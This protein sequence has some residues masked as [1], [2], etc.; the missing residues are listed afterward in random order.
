MANYFLGIDLGGTNIKIGCLDSSFNLLGKISVPSGPD[1]T[2]EL[3]VD[4]F[5]TTS[6]ELLE[7][8][9]LSL[10]DVDA[11]GVGSP[12]LVDLSKGVV[13]AAS[14]LPLFK[15]VFLKEMVAKRMNKPTILENDANAACWGEHIIGAGKGSNHMI[16]LTLG[17]GIGGG[18]ISDGKLI[19]GPCSGAAEL[20]HIIVYP[21]GRACTCG[22]KGCVE[23]YASA[24]STVNRAIE[25]IQNGKKSSLET[26]LKSQEKITCKDVF[27]HAEN[28]DAVAKKIIE[29]TAKVLAI[30]CV[31]MV[32]LTDPES[33]VFAG[34]MI[35]AGEPFLNQIRHFYKKYIGNLLNRSLNNI[36]FATLGEDAG[37]IGAAS[38]ALDQ[39]ND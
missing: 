20:G 26:K 25:A 15:N 31:Q 18:I 10:T 35:A 23:A 39:T 16:L 12:G 5:Y 19:H 2:A 21:D 32:N 33:I 11:V 37:I 34:G 28:G 3:I 30:A 22:Q 4:R 36:C 7:K 29:E 13:E 24:N 9:G 27:D 6:N 1:M 8:I 14:N 17:T 38:L